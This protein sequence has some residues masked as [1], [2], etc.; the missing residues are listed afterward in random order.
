[1]S[2]A[3]G[4][5]TKSAWQQP[6]AVSQVLGDFTNVSKQGL[7]CRMASHRALRVVNPLTGSL[8]FQMVLGIT[9]RHKTIMGLQS[10]QSER[11][12][13][14]DLGGVMGIICSCYLVHEN[15]TYSAFSSAFSTGPR[16]A[17]FIP[18]TMK[19]KKYHFGDTL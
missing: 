19:A 9:R 7:S 8:G 16:A 6:L 17:P 10:C 1:M 15:K 4:T 18:C 12:G 3:A 13:S 14:A 2:P 11:G 5:L